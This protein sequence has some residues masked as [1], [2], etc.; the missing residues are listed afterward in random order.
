[1]YYLHSCLYCSRHIETVLRARYRVAS[2]NYKMNCSAH[3]I[4]VELNRLG[5]VDKNTQETMILV[6][7]DLFD[8]KLWPELN[9]VLHP[10]KNKPPLLI[11]RRS[12]GTQLTLVQPRSSDNSMSLGSMYSELSL[13]QTRYPTNLLMIAFVDSDSSIMYYNLTAATCPPNYKGCAKQ[14]ALPTLV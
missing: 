3:P 12:L 1:M 8:V 10:D 13:I 2:E 5:I 7:N 9:L 14:Q 6:H 4:R 11:G